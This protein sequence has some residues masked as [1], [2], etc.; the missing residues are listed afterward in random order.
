MLLVTGHEAPLTTFGQLA[1]LDLDT[2]DVTRLGI[3]GTS[4]HY[5]S[6]GHVVYG[7]AGGVIRAVPF[8]AASLTATGDPVT[9]VDG[10]AGGNG[11]VHFSLSDTGTL[12]YVSGSQVGVP[13]RRYVWVDQQ[14]REEVL[15]LPVSGYETVR[16]SPSGRRI[17]VESIDQE[18]MD[19]WVYDALS[20]RGQ[21][22]TR[23]FV[24]QSLVWSHDGERIFFGSHHEA[25][26]NI[27]SV[28]ADGSGEVELLLS[29]DEWDYPHSVTPDRRTIAFTRQSGRDSE[30]EIWEMA[31]DGGTELPVPLLQRDSSQRSPAYSPD[32]DWLAYA[33]DESGEIE[34]Y[35]R[36]YPGPGEVVPV[37]IGGGASPVWATDGSRLFYVHENQVTAVMFNP[38]GPVQIGS[39]T[40]LFEAAFVSPRQD[41]RYDIAPDGRLLLAKDEVDDF[42]SEQIPP[43][44]VVFQ[45]WFQELTERVPVN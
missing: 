1:V 40:A 37:S 16:V 28:P 13:Q 34:V 11:P 3:T 45:N 32:G 22:L 29:S 15:S 41:R 6:T 20:G 39:P 30:A 42:G 9:L 5:V 8:D 21:R 24:I 38:G 4:P 33:S 17:A 36:P 44:V 7:G 27:Y 10:V 25:H 12:V 23:G 19:L 18:G 35:V 2:R 26:A 43:Q 14:G 31:L